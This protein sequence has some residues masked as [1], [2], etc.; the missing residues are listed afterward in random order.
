MLSVRTPG[1]VFRPLD[2]V[3]IGA[4][5]E[6]IFVVWDGEGR[7]YARLPAGR[8]VALRVSGSLGTHVVVHLDDEGRVLDRA[9]FRVDCATEIADEHGRFRRLLQMLYDTLFQHWTRGYTKFLRIEGKRYKYYVSWLRD[10]VHALKGM[11]YWDD[12]VETGIE[13]Y[14]DSQR[15]DGMIWDKCKEMAHSHL[16]FWRD[17]EFAYGDFIRKIPGNPTRRWQRVPVE[18]DVE[19]LFIEG[20]YYTWKACG[21]DEWME[22]LLDN[23]V[24]AVHYSTSDRYRW[25]EKFRLLKRGYTID[26]WDFQTRDDAERSGS[27][28]RVL[29]GKTEF[30]IFH[31]D[32]TGMA[33]ACRYL[34]E[35]LAVAGRDREAEEFRALGLELKERLDDLSWNGEFYTH[36]VPENPDAERDLGET[37]TDRQVTLSN[38]YALNRRIDHEQCV[39]IIESYRRIR[40]E[41]PESSVGEWYNCYPPFEKGFR[42]GGW[43]YMN[44]GVSTICAGELAHGA[45]EHG[46]EDYA[47]DILRRVIELGER[48]GGYLP[49]TFKGKLPDPPRDVTFNPLDLTGA[50]N[51]DPNGRGAEGVPGW[52]G[53][54]E[55]DMCNLPTGRRSFAGIDFEVI[56]PAENGRRAVL[57]ISS[58]ECYKPEETV[59][60]GAKA[61]TLHLLH[62]ADGHGLIGWMTVR[63]AAGGHRTQYIHTGQ[64]MESWFMPAPDQVQGRIRRDGPYRI[65]WQGP[66]RKF[67]NVGIFVY[68]WENP[69]PDREIESITFTAAERDVVW[70]I[71]GITLSDAERYF[72]VSIVSYGIPDM[73]GAAALVY[74]LMEG[75]AGIVDEGKAY[76]RVRLSPRWA[77]AGVERATACAKYP[78]SGGYVRYTYCLDREAGLLSLEMAGNGEETELE[79]L[80][81]DGVGVE[82]LTVDGGDVG[83]PQTFEI[84]GSRYLR[85]RLEGLAVHTV[86]A[87]LG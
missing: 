85:V 83:E 20:L 47:V 68:G 40:E 32:N 61:R 29:P 23:A 3:R 30:N 14:A 86:T 8:D 76:E 48:L 16:Q 54:P 33:V 49:N 46:Y 41:M 75:L 80:L 13:L 84:E 51:V 36:M 12:D 57:G 67:D 44:G 25:S 22:G 11:K 74:A 62:A 71:A 82:M 64:E 55:N 2:T 87:R 6:G 17:H 58:R 78:A 56:D 15:E 34:A 79:L 42:H 81:P 21:D 27:I 28:M 43:D 10:H 53:D 73:W 38:A 35:M 50:A 19:F 26:T 77:A 66:N 65:G 4:E 70:L 24:R 59:Q 72:P 39:A 45:F 7:Q 69:R 52:T 5:G 1:R 60:V 18:N 37:P 31:G 63:Y 9:R